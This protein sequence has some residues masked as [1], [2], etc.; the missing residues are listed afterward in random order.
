VALC[1]ILDCKLQE[2]QLRAKISGTRARRRGREFPRPRC[3]A[4]PPYFFRFSCASPLVSSLIRMWFVPPFTFPP[5]LC[6]RRSSRETIVCPPHLFPPPSSPSFRWKGSWEHDQCDGDGDGDH[7]HACLLLCAG[8]DFH[9]N[10]C[11][12]VRKRMGDCPVLVPG[13]PA[14]IAAPHLS[15]TMRKNFA[16]VCAHRAHAFTRHACCT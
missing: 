4:V 14:V 11:A 7:D 15:Q 10:L 8:C 16:H 12:K 6:V 1:S 2:I 13:L 3:G 9:C 5:S